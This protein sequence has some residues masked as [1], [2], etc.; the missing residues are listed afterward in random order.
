MLIIVAIISL[1]VLIL[2]TETLNRW[3]ME[4]F[5]NVIAIKMLS[6]FIFVLIIF[7]SVSLIYTFGPSLT[8]RFSFVSAG[9]VLATISMVLTTTVFFFLVNHF[10]N[11]NKVYGS[12]GSLIAFM[13]WLWLNTFAILVG[14]ELNVS[15]LLGKLARNEDEAQ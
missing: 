11:Y 10:I 5:E 12:I 6:L 8:H 14:Y 4:I 7:C 15:I 1:A 9:S 2:Q 13:V 3:M